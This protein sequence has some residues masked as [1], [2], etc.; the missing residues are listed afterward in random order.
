M[1]QS[2]RLIVVIL[3][4]ISAGTVS[5]VCVGRLRTRL[6]PT[7]VFF[8]SPGLIL[9]SATVGDVEGW[10]LL[11]T[12]CAMTS[13]APRVALSLES[14]GRSIEVSSSLSANEPIRATAFLS[15]GVRFAGGR[16]RYPERVD[17]MDHDRLS[18][19]LA[20][21]MDGTLGWDVLRNY[22]IGIDSR[23]R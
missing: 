1:R 15:G 17:V 6:S 12:G 23:Q 13:V 5:I 3:V 20:H 22:V 7:P 11:D 10:Y 2:T 19:L 18:V 14:T 21:D 4:A 16:L 9:A 8:S